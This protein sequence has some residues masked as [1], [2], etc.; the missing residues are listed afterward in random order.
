M[1]KSAKKLGL[2]LFVMLLCLLVRPMQVNAGNVRTGTLG[3]NNGITWTYDEDTKTL[4]ITGEDS[5]LQGTYDSDT[6]SYKSPFAAICEDVEVIKVQNCTLKVACTGLFA[7]LESLKSIEF[8]NFDTSH[9]TSMYF[10]FYNCSSLSSLDLSNFDTSYVTDMSCMFEGCSSLSSLDVS[11]FDTSKVT[12][13][14]SMFEGCSSLSSLDVSNFDT[15]RVTKMNC[16]FSGCSSLSTLDLSNFDT[17]YVT[18]MRCMFEGCS[19][20]SSVDVSNFDTSNAYYMNGMFYGCSSLSSLD[21]SKFNTSKVEYMGDMFFGCSS[22][23]S[24]DLSNFDTS[25]V[26]NM[27]C[28]FEGCSSLSSLDVSNF[29]TSNVTD[30]SYMFRECSG[31]SSLDVSNFNT[32]NVTDMSGMFYDCSSLSSLDVS[33]FNTGNVTSMRSMFDGCG[34]LTGLDISSFDLTKV[35][36]TDRAFTGC[37]NLARIKTPKTIPETLSIDLPGTYV[38]SKG[39]QTK[40]LTKAFCNTTLINVNYLVSEIKLNSSSITVHMG[41]TGQLTATVSP[42]QALDKTLTWKSSNTAVAKV[43]ANGKVTPVAPGT[44]T[45]TVTA[46]DG[47]GKSAS[48]TVSVKDENPFADVKESSWQYASAKY[49]YD[50]GLMAGKGQDN[51]GNIIFDPNK[52]IPREEFVQVLYNASGK[53]VVSIDNEFPDVKDAW[54][55]N[56]VLWAKEKNIANGKGDGNFGVTESISRQDL[57]LMLYKY[58]A[59]NGYDLTVNAGE[60]NKYADGS[61][62]SSYAKTAMDWAITKGVMSGKGKKGEDISTFRLD[63]AGTATRAECAAML[64]NF[65]EVYGE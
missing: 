32:G 59:L 26:T 6:W 18:N 19:S 45:I 43:D 23:N 33:N 4:T 24:L 51:E 7:G 50:N 37:T 38:N 64:K 41:K 62:V 17:S 25:R 13:M 60:I 31:L 30:M 55:K 63:P 2:A 49:A 12:D 47:S 10:M 11:N 58:A 53:P 65:M 54:Y 28:M 27:S 52:A 48:C 21:V 29:D 1:Q 39:D 3:E 56:A 40:Q 46:T 35:T 34:S 22:L 42:Q 8:Q 57:A 5:G 9:I 36:S 61:K 20:L 15:S 14:S 44:A 16:M